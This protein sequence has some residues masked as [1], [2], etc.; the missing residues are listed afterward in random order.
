MPLS[1]P[2]DERCEGLQRAHEREDPPRLGGP[3]DELGDLRAAEH[4]GR[5]AQARHSRPRV[6]AP[7]GRRQ[8]DD[9]LWCEKRGMFN[10]NDIKG[11]AKRLRPG[12]MNAA[13]KL[14]QN[15]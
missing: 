13:G 1:V 9:D 15:W 12:C 3:V 7:L 4:R 14:R 10:Y 11:S 6:H 2:A 5:V 8:R